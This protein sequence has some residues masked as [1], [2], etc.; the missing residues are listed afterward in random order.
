MLLPIL[1]IGSGSQA[2]SQNNG[3]YTIDSDQLKQI[4]LLE[5]SERN[6]KDMLLI[7]DT[8]ID[9]LKKEVVLLKGINLQLEK[10]N[11]LNMQIISERTA[12]Y[13][14]CRKQKEFYLEET[15]RLT[16]SNS[17]KKAVM[18]SSLIMNIIFLTVILK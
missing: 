8:Q 7:Y 10:Q 17:I 1:M 9:T 18:A 5:A 4:R 2:V 16:R 14:S 13:N 12:Q 3:K 11:E 15:V 6:C